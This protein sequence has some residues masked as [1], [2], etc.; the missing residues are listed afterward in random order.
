MLQL[1][2]GNQLLIE[3]KWNFTITG[4]LSVLRISKHFSPPS[5]ASS[6]LAGALDNLLETSQ[7]AAFRTWPISPQPRS[8][9]KG[10]QRP[11]QFLGCPSRLSAEENRPGPASADLSVLSL[12]PPAPCDCVTLDM[13]S[14]PSEP[15][16]PSL[17]NPDL[18][19]S[20]VLISFD[21]SVCPVL[22]AISIQWR[23]SKLTSSF[24]PRY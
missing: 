5:F 20:K 2:K 9:R 21:D 23:T 17:Q 1:I 22:A 18:I 4:H 7:R 24:L 16:F 12:L 3:R 10:K 14:L 8:S 13:S 19:I 11:G 15:H 6:A